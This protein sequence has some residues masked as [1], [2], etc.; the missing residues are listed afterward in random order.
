LAL[1][2]KC[3]SIVTTRSGGLTVKSNRDL[4]DGRGDDSSEAL[5][6]VPTLFCIGLPSMTTVQATTAS[7]HVFDVA[8]ILDRG[9][10]HP[11]QKLILLLAS[12]VAM[13]DGVDSGVLSLALPTIAKDWG[14]PR[15]AFAILMALSF[16]ATAIG[17]AVGGFAGDRLGRKTALIGSTCAFGAFTLAG[18]F[19][20]NL[21]GLGLMRGFAALGLGAAMPNVATL[22]A[23]YTPVRQ[24]SIALGIS[25]SAPPV[26]GIVLGLLSAF[27]LSGYGWQALFVV[28]G[29]LPLLVAVLVLAFLPESLRFL[30]RNP[31]NL[32]KI[33]KIVSSMRSPDFTISG[34]I[35]TGETASQKRVPVSAVL[36]GS[37]ARDT[38]LIGFAFFFVVFST[39][40]VYT[41]SPTLLTDLGYSAAFIGTGL[42]CFS[43]GGL[44][45]GIIG[46]KFVQWVGSR[47]ALFGM[48]MV[49]VACAASMAVLLWITDGNAGGWMFVGLFCAGFVIPGTGAVIYVLAGQIYPTSF[50][51]TGVGVT[52]GLGRF[53]AVTSAFVGPFLLRGHGIP[54]FLVI[55]TT[56]LAVALTLLAVRRRVEKQGT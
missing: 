18:A 55:A 16:V 38:Y 40:L 30:V 33:D 54:F 52:A 46:A 7:S 20:H 32:A 48:S 15:S 51:A 37:F 29:G 23:E 42:S 17:T 35:D 21:L 10:W 1:S 3:I 50:R 9:E 2:G 11:R 36:S 19:S 24:R 45:G 56:M 26:G 12:L 5:I 53:G 49:A 41:W 22:V 34:F 8:E 27:I 39:T 6:T 14:E 28:A 4:S 31:A 43:A 44:I 47:S 13:V 25:M